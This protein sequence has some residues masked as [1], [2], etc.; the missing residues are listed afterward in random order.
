MDRK[1]RLLF[2]GLF[3]V[4]LA[5]S[6]FTQSGPLDHAQVLGRLAQGYG[7]SYV[8]HLVKT[9]GVSFSSSGYFIELVKL[10]GGDGIL[11]ERL[12]AS[13]ASDRAHSISDPEPSYDHLASC[14]ELNGQACEALTIKKQASELDPQ[15]SEIQKR[16]E[17]FREAAQQVASRKH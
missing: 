1:C 17:H 7:P 16:L 8:A 12:F 2:L 3:C 11:V 10:A 9:R 4:L 5:P 14:A 13:E 6:G 15:N